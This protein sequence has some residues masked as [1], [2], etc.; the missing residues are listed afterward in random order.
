MNL[1]NIIED[2]KILNKTKSILSII[3]MLSV[4]LIPIELLVGFIIKTD[5]WCVVY[6]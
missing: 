5:I 3:V 4:L 1:Y 6:C 2:V